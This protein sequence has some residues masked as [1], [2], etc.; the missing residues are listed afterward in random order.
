M[1]PRGAF[2]TETYTRKVD[3]LDYIDW[4]WW[5]C[6]VEAH[7]SDPRVEWQADMSFDQIAAC[8][9]VRA[10][11]WAMPAVGDRAG[12]ELGTA[13]LY[14]PRTGPERTYTSWPSS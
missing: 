9:G 12:T 5:L 14:W 7:R 10:G 8:A 1:V 11:D 2:H 6:E 13:Q 3:V 4:V